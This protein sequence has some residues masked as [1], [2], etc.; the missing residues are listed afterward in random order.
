MVTLMLCRFEA[1]SHVL[2]LDPPEPILHVRK[3]GR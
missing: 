2:A 3:H 1:I